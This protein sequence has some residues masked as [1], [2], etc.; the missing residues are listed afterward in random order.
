MPKSKSLVWFRRDLRSF[1]HAAL[2]RALAGSGSVYCAFVFD[3]DILAGLPPDDRRVHFIH[4]SLRELDADLRR[5]G[6]GLIV[7]HGRAEEEIPRLAAELGVETVF[8]NHDYE[9]AAIARDNRVA[10]KLGAD[11]RLF[12]TSKDQVVFERSEVLTLGGQPFSVFTPYKNAWLRQ[13]AANPDALAPHE[14]EPLAARLAPAPAASALPGLADI[15]FAEPA[16]PVAPAGM[17]GAADLFEHFLDRIASYGTAR[18]FPADDATSRLS[19]HLRFGT[20]SIRHLVRTARQMAA[21]G[22]AGA[23]VW[24]SELIWR[25][26]YAMILYHHPRVVT[27]SFKSAFDAIAWEQ[28]QA[29]DAAFAAWCEGRTGYPLV[30]AAMAQLNQTGFMHNRLR[31]LTASFLTKDLGIDWRRGERYFALKLNDYDLASNNGG[32]QWAASTGCDAQPWFR[33]FNPLTQ[34]R[35]FDPDG[36]FIRRYLP[37]LAALDAREIHAPMLAEPMLLLAK[38]VQMGRDYAWPIVEHERARKQTLAR[39]EAIRA[40]AG[41]A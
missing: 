32:W 25:E 27:Q 26:F 9:P 38:G 41:E 3:T 30:D 22:A 35:K 17:S 8:A 29:A 2:H 37:Q 24:L 4:A 11:G 7:R 13:L 18:D 10:R 39:F 23:E 40:A 33:I 16:N 21:H 34:S 20:T 1:D 12:A 31:M 36:N 19:V 6:G 15:G 14:I 5:L 28:G